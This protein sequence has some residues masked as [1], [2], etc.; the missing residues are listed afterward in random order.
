[1]PHL[2]HLHHLTQL[3]RKQSEYR[4]PRSNYTP[5]VKRNS[6]VK[7]IL[8][9]TASDANRAQHPQ[10]SVALLPHHPLCQKGSQGRGF[11]H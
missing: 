3:P 4:R 11:R 8:S 6:E 5:P 1:M 10:A 9:P 2:H 7:V